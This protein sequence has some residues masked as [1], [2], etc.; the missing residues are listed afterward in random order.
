M[1]GLLLLA[2]VIAA[3][4]AAADRPNVVFILPHAVGW[5]DLGCY[6]QKKIHTPNI[7]HL[8]TDGMRFTQA[9]AGNAVCAP[10]RCCLMTGKHPG[11]AHVRD[12]RQWSRTNN[13]RARSRSRLI[14]S[15]CQ[16]CSKLPGTRP[17][18]WASG[19]FGPRR[20]PATP[21]TKPS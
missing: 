21:P 3:P 20:T 6:G 12:N 7:D 1:R 18:R 2:G 8:A 15:R 13:G 5:G 17:G 16:S 14:R 4:A 11:H 10:S 9:Y 19:A